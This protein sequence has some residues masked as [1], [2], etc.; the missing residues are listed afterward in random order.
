LIRIWLLS[1]LFISFFC[2]SDP[3]Q[4]YPILHTKKPYLE[5]SDYKDTMQRDFRLLKEGM[6]GQYYNFKAHFSAV[7]NL[8][9]PGYK[10][11]KFVNYLHNDEDIIPVQ[12]IDWSRERPIQS[13]RRLDF[14]V[15]GGLNLF[16]LEPQNGVELYTFDGRFYRDSD[17]LLRSVAHYLPVLGSKGPIYLSSSV[18]EVDSEGQIFENE[19][20]VDRLKVISFKNPNGLWTID[21]TVF[22]KREPSKVELVKNPKYDILQGYYEGA[23][24]P[25]GMMTSPTI[26]PF[27]EGMAKSAKTYIETYE[28]F[29]K[30]I[31]D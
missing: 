21:G 2:Y 10:R 14:Y 27:G 22:Y 20:V 13:D 15:S 3:G 4:Q 16:C 31:D 19:V 7:V 8:K 29:F 12:Y 24:E 26:I 11:Y 9:T 30:A 18:P 23:N 28:L 5:R 17:G 25:P 1:T 6:A